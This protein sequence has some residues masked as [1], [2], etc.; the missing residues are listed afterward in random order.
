MAARLALPARA[1]QPRVNFC[2]YCGARVPIS[3]G[4]GQADSRLV[5][6]VCGETTRAMGDQGP[7]VL[8]LTYVLAR[9]RL[10]LIQRG[11]NPYIGQWA[12]PG[13]FV[14]RGESLER[15]AVREIWEETGVELDSERLL[16]FATLSL[17]VINQVYFMF[18]ASLE[19]VLSARSNPPES[20]A[21][22][23]F[24]EGDLRAVTQWE[25][26]SHVDVPALF[27]GAAT[28]RFDFHQLSDEFSRIV[29]NRGAT[30]YRTRRS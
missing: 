16:P 13:G 25:P 14:E 3:S 2:A 24:S 23:W 22:D 27:A 1:L 7:A 21:A 10:L 9:G 15:A 30:T 4:G 12:P 19:D 11:S 29:I 17:P 8:V 5:C 28:G 6:P 26:A 18:A 20:V